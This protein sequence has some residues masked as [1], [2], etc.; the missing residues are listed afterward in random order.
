MRR[1]LAP[2]IAFALLAP[3]LAAG[4][5][6][7]AEEHASGSILVPNPGIGRAQRCAATTGAGTP[8]EQGV[9]GFTLDVTP[10]NA[11][12]VTA[13][14]DSGAQD[15]DIVFYQSLTP[16]EE[17][18]AVTDNPH[19]NVDG[20][21]YGIVPPDASTAVVT[22]HRGT[23]GASFVYD[24]ESAVV[25]P[26]PGDDVVVAVIDTGTRVSH[27]EFDYCDCG[28]ESTGTTDDPDPDDQVVAWWDFTDENPDG[29]PFGRELTPR[30]GDI[31][32]QR[33]ADPFDHHGHGT[34]TASLAVGQ[35]ADPIKERSFAPG[36]KLAVAKVGDGGGSVSGDVR[37]AMQWATETVGADVVSISIG[38]IAP[39]P[40]AFYHAHEY[41]RVAREHGALVVVANGNG[42]G[43][44]G[45]GPGEP[46]WAKP[47]GE[48]PHVLAVGA[49]GHASGP[50]L[51]GG[52][53]ATN[54]PEVT[55]QY[56]QVSVAGSCDDCYR[57]T[58]GTS[59]AAPLVSG[60][61]ARLIHEARNAGQASDP[62][63]I[64]TLL[65]HSAR[66]TQ[67][68]PV[69]E[70]YGRLDYHQM[71]GPDGAIAQA[72][73]EDDPAPNSELNAFYV[74]EVRGLLAEHWANETDNRIESSGVPA[75]T[76]E[77]VIGPSAFTGLGEAD[78]YSFQASEGQLVEIAFEYGEDFGNDV[79]LFA[80]EGAGPPLH[81]ATQ[82]IDRSTNGFPVEGGP[83]EFI[84]FRAPA[85]GTYSLVALGWF[86][87]VD[88][89][90]DL[91]LTVDGT[92]P[93]IDF[94]DEYVLHTYGF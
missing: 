8:A 7:S 57:L 59:F 32:Y 29:D 92:T 47:Y 16:C 62:E 27:Q 93:A 1:R 24:E 5:T 42:W 22:L 49:T 77:G 3:F 61:A 40:E 39:L 91:T 66:D 34:A 60:M 73:T 74:E 31:W 81:A 35:N 52:Y 85:D 10:G 30:P 48:S 75:S 76:G 21:E 65:K 15:F 33:V 78:I 28:S 37:E 46:G 14:D 88:Q 89:P 56:R 94:S 68:P 13:V 43:G 84:A 54:D 55:S 17:G 53:T 19:E 70:G 38:A 87:Y 6:A 11:F 23:P 86:V 26:A 79:D 64:E 50:D 4:P 58:G 51:G 36:Y 69:D 67:T 90:Y 41:A 44:I 18:A 80:F 25:D 45:L 20:D 12:S 72:R 9:L 82:G 71:H 83:D 63:R 2:L